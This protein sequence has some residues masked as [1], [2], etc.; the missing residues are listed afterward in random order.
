MAFGSPLYPQS[1]SLAMVTLFP[2]LAM[3]FLQ[4]NEDSHTGPE[5]RSYGLFRHALVCV[6]KNRLSIVSKKGLTAS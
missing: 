2:C 6:G 3:R 4:R 5:S 1:T